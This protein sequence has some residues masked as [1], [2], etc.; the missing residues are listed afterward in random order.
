MAR[1]V[2]ALLDIPL[3]E[4]FG[5]MSFL[6]AEGEAM[7]DPMVIGH[8][9]GPLRP[10]LAE[11]TTL[12]EL[13]PSRMCCDV[14]SSN[15]T[16]VDLAGVTLVAG[17]IGYQFEQRCLELGLPKPEL[18]SATH[19]RHKGAFWIEPAPACHRRMTRWLE[20]VAPHAFKKRSRAI[21][22]LMAWC[23]PRHPT[24]VA[25]LW[26]TSDKK[27]REVE[28]R[29]QMRIFPRLAETKD[30]LRKRLKTIADFYLQTT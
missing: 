8:P 20:D 6:V 11:G 13:V 18:P 12:E 21:A 5:M 10:E 7:A 22:T 19:G 26:F 17:W 16:H 25:A 15:L 29:N 28:I 3:A 24:T 27:R 2:V 1:I 9:N 23:D 30:D 14:R 4:S